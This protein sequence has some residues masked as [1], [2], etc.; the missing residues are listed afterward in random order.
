MHKWIWRKIYDRVT[1]LGNLLR[2]TRPDYDGNP[3]LIR[4]TESEL[5]EIQEEIQDLQAH[6]EMYL[7][8]IGVPYNHERRKKLLAKKEQAAYS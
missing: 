8:K 3:A 4:L 1:Y 5:E 2:Y 6:S 7:D